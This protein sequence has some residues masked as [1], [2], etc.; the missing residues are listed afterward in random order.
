MILPHRIIGHK[1]F[2]IVDNEAKTYVNSYDSMCLC[3]SKLLF[4]V[5]SRFKVLSLKDLNGRSKRRE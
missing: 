2:H 3:G 1:D 5:G 4:G